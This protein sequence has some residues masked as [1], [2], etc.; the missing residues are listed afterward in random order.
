MLSLFHYTACSVSDYDRK[1]IVLRF[2]LIVHAKSI[3]G[4][5]LH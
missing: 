1:S 5:T 4:V 3:K 2:L